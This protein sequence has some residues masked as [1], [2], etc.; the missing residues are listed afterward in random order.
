M[1]AI[2][3]L[4]ISKD[5]TGLEAGVS[6][7]REDC[8]RRCRERG[9]TLVA[10][11]ADNDMSATTGRRRP[12]FEAMLN[13]LQAGEADVVVAW[14]LDRLQRNRRDELRLYDA[15]RTMGASMS[16]VN[17]P[18]IDF[19]TATGRYLADNLGS[20][21]RLEVEL[22]SD[23]QVR[24]QE[25]AAAQGRRVG[26]RRPF[27]YEQDG[28]TI[29][30]AEAAAVRDG[31]DALLAGVPLAAIA[32][33]WNARGLTTGQNNR[34]GQPS[35][36][37]ADSVR[38]VLLNPRYAG[39]RAHKGQVIGEAVW[40]ALVE[41]TTWQATVATLTDAGRRSGA[42]GRPQALLTGIALCGICG[43][44]VQAGGA[45]RPGVR[46]YRC[47]GSMGHFARMAEP[48]EEFVSALMVGRLSRVDAS[49]LL[50]DSN[51]PDVDALRTEAVALRKR[52]EALAV[53]FADGE[54]TTSQIKAA[55]RRVRARLSEVETE[56]ADAGRV[57]VLGPLVAAADVSA[58]WDALTTARRRA[59]IDTLATVKL[60][61][62]GR[63]TRTFRPETVGIEWKGQP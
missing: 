15:C 16:L 55:T 1:R 33:E 43:A 44:P 61:P 11:H 4:R 7:Q 58:A 22:K 5:R 57:D 51:K 29:R 45:A 17:G 6:R 27:G 54:L 49:D 10:E 63:G 19:T 14:A 46:G 40:P 42:R 50:V 20:L 62:V 3:Y 47:G 53:D 12:G 52:L 37:R 35:P 18:D 38:H 32:R 8:E 41:E 24:Q 31:Y 56:M 39:Q 13:A 36:W 26:G 34:Q 59:V 2:V 21:A 28:T 25:Q 30:E 23:R 48:V 9:W 60:H